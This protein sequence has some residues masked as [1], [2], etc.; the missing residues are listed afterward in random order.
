MFLLV[1]RYIAI[2]FLFF[3]CFFFTGMCAHA[4]P[5]GQNVRAAV[6]GGKG[7]VQAPEWLLKRSR[8]V[9]RERDARASN[10]GAINKGAS[11][12]CAW[13]KGRLALFYK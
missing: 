4:S 1:P 11:K 12:D 6:Q 8:A 5:S 9:G 13:G 3:L 7:C 2:F 10:T